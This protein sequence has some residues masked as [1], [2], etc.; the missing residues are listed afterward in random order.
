MED[1]GK[2]LQDAGIIKGEAV[3]VAYQMSHVSMRTD[4]AKKMLVKGG[5]LID[6]DQ[7]CIVIESNRETVAAANATGVY[8]E[9]LAA[10][11]AREQWDVCSISHVPKAA[12][13]ERAVNETA[14]ED[15]DAKPAHA[16]RRHGDLVAAP[17]DQNLRQI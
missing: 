13:N 15:M 10:V 7:L 5:R 16:K 12:A 14:A 1:F 6:N 2:P 9:N 3:T 11:S 4:E 17:H 8:A